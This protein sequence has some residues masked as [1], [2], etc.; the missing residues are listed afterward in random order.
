MTRSI[1]LTAVALIAAS[2]AQATTIID[3]KGDFLPSYTGPHTADLDVLSASA[4]S[5][6]GRFLLSGK[7]AGKVGTTVGADYAWGINRGAGVPGLAF[8]TPSIGTGVLFDALAVLFANGT[9][10]VLD[11]NAAGPPT[12]SRSRRVRSLSR[13][14]RSVR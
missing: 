10:F 3:P 12:Q 11:F 6:G 7:L 5:Q 4:I 9:G 2:T 8:G 1:L 13:A 14:I